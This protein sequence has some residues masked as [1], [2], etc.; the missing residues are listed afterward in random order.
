M[1]LLDLIEKTV[2]KTIEGVSSIPAVTF[3]I[4]KGVV[5]GVEKGIENISET[6]DGIFED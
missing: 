3:K 5:D 6:L 2:E 4:G 1:G